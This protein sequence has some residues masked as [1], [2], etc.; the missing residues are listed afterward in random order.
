MTAARIVAVTHDRG[1][2]VEPEWLARA[3][4]VHRQLRPQLPDNYE[5]AMPFN[6]KTQLT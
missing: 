2:I 5:A 6:F 3:E 4:R 1:R